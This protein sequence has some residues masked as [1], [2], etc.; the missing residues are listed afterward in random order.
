MGKLHDTHSII[1]PATAADFTA[2]TYCEV[3]AGAGATPTIN[4]VSVVMAAGST[5]SLKVRSIS[6]TANIYLLGE[7]KNYSADGQSLR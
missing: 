2:H 4:G 1:V 5:L 6:P 3:Y 7:N